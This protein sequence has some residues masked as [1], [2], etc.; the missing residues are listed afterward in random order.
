MNR[1]FRVQK[2]ERLLI[3]EHAGMR[4]VM[5]ETVRAAD[6]SLMRS[7]RGRVTLLQQLQAFVQVVLQ[8]I[9]NQMSYDYV[10]S[11]IVKEI[12]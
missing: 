8:Q 3:N 12:L 9:T 2:V 1:Q 5:E 10:T 11:K 7:R 4:V 6:V